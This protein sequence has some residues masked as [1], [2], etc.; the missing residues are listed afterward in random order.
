MQE[1][2]EEKDN[3]IDIK[4]EIYK[5]LESTGNPIALGIMY[6]CKVVIIY[7]SFGWISQT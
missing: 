4:E 3:S 2:K 7:K 5:D 1:E 6:P